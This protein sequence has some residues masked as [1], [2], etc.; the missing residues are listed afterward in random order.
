MTDE[1]AVGPEPTEILSKAAA[2]E[3]IVTWLIASSLCRDERAFG[4]FMSFAADRIPVSEKIKLLGKIVE[5]L[6]HPSVVPGR[7]LDDLRLINKVR[8]TV[9][10]SLYIEVPPSDGAPAGHVMFKKGLP[11]S[12]S[13]A[14]LRAQVAAAL[15]ATQRSMASFVTIAQASGLMEKQQPDPRTF[16][17]PQQYSRRTR[18]KATANTD[19]IAD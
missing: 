4:W 5:S 19:D 16:A 15:A 11:T 12:V 7:F 13:D 9:A 17:F 8:V 10:H 2:V 14:D 3:N 18:W 6:P 1:P